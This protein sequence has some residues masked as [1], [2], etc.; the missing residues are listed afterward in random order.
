MIL[1]TVGTEKFPFNRL[2]KWVEH[3][4]NQGLINPQQEPI[5]IQ[6]GSCTFLPQGA[7]HHQL[8]PEADFQS[9]LEQARVIISHCGEGSFDILTKLNKPF[10]LVPRS[11]EF[12][13]HVDDHQVELAQALAIKGVP[14]AHNPG[15][16]VRFLANPV[17]VNSF[18]A[19]TQYYQQ[20]SQLLSKEIEQ[21][22]G[23]KPRINILEKLK[24]TGMAFT[25]RLGQLVPSFG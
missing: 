5:V 4:I 23:K 2:M 9:L 3:L 11:Q 10:V 19:P 24:Q 1:I 6:Y 13:E 21:F 15:D 17:I 18:A 8:L 12:G 20:A 14:V 16:L 22:H 25:R 7:N